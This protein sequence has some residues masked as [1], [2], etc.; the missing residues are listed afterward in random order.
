MLDVMYKNKNNRSKK[1]IKYKEKGV[2]KE[3]NLDK[4]TGGKMKM[5]VNESR[6]KYAKKT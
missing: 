3:K 1:S 4:R 5:S 6:M 2:K